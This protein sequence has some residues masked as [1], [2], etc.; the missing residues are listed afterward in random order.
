MIWHVE[1]VCHP[2]NQTWNPL[3]SF[4]FLFFTL[5]NLYPTYKNC[6]PK[7]SSRSFSLVFFKIVYS[8]YSFFHIIQKVKGIIQESKGLLYKKLGH[9][10][11]H[12]ETRGIIQETKGLFDNFLILFKNFRYLPKKFMIFSERCI[13]PLLGGGVRL[14]IRV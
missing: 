7:N 8:P 9:F 14:E 12:F 2:P 3:L 1:K 13:L 11:P 10:S 5:F 6:P 4:A